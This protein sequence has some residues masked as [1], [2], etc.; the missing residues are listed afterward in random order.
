MF[1]ILGVGNET[2]F[3]PHTFDI[4]INNFCSLKL[5]IKKSESLTRWYFFTHEVKKEFLSPGVCVYH[6]VNQLLLSN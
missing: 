4:R 6:N 2:G 5:S 3:L 1:P